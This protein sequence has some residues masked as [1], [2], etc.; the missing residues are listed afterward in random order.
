MSAEN[1]PGERA[2]ALL[3]QRLGYRFNDVGLLESALTHKSFVNENPNMGRHHGER[4]EFLGD[5]VIDLAVGHLVM[6]RF[7]AGREGELSIAR[8]A[9][10]NE[11][12][13]AALASDLGLGDWLFLGRGEDHSGG[14]KKASILA[15]AC[16]AVFGAIFLDCGYQQTFQVIEKLVGPRVD[17]LD[18]PGYTDFKTRL[19]ERAQH[20]YKETPRYTLM[21]EVG[22][23]HAKVFQV[24][25]AIGERTFAISVGRSKKEAEQNAA[26]DA[27]FLL[28]GEDRNE[29]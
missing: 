15:D 12:G 29:P 24:S 11:S 13:L 27:L 6:R 10:V 22:P 9:L 26:R 5:A 4:L 23:D 8:A 16:E 20:F 7:P 18:D 19:Q 21:V 25:V 2:Y 3:E 28:E 14:R 17:A 1:P